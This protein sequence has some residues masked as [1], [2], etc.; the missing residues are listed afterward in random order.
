[1]HASMTFPAKASGVVRRRVVLGDVWRI[2]R[3]VAAHGRLYATEWFDASD[4]E[5]EVDDYEAFRR[6]ANRDMGKPSGSNRENR[7]LGAGHWW[8]LDAAG[9]RWKLYRL[10]PTAVFSQPQHAV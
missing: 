10:P 7:P 8:L 2:N 5:E 3:L 4:F 9:G 1:M 6:R